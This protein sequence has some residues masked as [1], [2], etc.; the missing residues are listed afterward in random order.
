MASP[1]VPAAPMVPYPTMSSSSSSSV[2][3]G[4]PP[5]PFMH[6]AA[7]PQQPMWMSPA[8]GLP[9]TFHLHQPLTI[10]PP[11]LPLP[12]QF[13]PATPAQPHQPFSYPA[14]PALQA[15]YPLG[16]EVLHGMAVIPSPA[17]TP[18][19]SSSMLPSLVTVYK[20]R[21]CGATLP[22]AEAVCTRLHAGGKGLWGGGGGGSS[23]SSSGSGTFSP[24]KIQQTTAAEAVYG[25][26]SAR[27]TE[28]RFDF[29]KDV[30]IT[31]GG[32]SSSSSNGAT[33]AV[34]PPAASNGGPSTT[35]SHNGGSQYPNEKAA[36]A[37]AYNSAAYGAPTHDPAAIY[38]LR[39]MSISSPSSSSTMPQP[40]P[41]PLSQPSYLGRSKSVQNPMVSAKKL[42]RD[43]RKEAS[44]QGSELMGRGA[45]YQQQHAHRIV[46]S[47]EGMSFVPGVGNVATMGRPSQY[48]QQ[49][50]QQQQL[51]N[52]GYPVP[53]GT[54]PAGGM[55]GLQR[56]ATVHYTPYIPSYPRSGEQ[57]Q[58]QQQSPQWQARPSA[59]GASYPLP[60][61][62]SFR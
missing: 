29:S 7:A 38:D 53:P 5:A 17:L 8:V 46:V 37:A 52:T 26:K 44:Q 49:Q 47:P 25:E 10:Q 27:R 14:Y 15:T 59:P 54:M 13:M 3:V 34:T 35:T 61:G 30:A 1:I 12:P 60:P 51:Q 42:W 18:S 20:C 9:Q 24:E 31:N 40:Q 6:G 56:H 58:Q 33:A 41:Q 21:K 28:K 48:R 16:A 50:Q 22:S 23:G 43:F 19:S 45:D 11:P 55:D 4:G 32:G 62:P 2:G 36:L 39:E 57:L